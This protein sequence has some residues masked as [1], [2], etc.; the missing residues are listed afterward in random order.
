MGL[1]H[2][3]RSCHFTSSIMTPRGNNAGS[4]TYAPLL[5]LARTP[6]ASSPPSLCLKFLGLERVAS[7]SLSNY[8]GTRLDPIRGLIGTLV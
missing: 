6:V 1:P 5:P 8:G 4:R 3:G 2:L 7:P